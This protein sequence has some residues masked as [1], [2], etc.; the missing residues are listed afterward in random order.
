MGWSSGMR[1]DGKEAGYGIPDTCGHEGC[2]KE[3]NRGISYTCGGIEYL[4]NFYGCGEWFCESHLYFGTKTFI[5]AACIQAEDD[6]SDW[7]EEEQDLEDA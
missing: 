5:C 1:S 6:I 4:S 3:I 7:L 2:S